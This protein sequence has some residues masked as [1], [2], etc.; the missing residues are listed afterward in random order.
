MTYEKI[1]IVGIHD[2]P[3]LAHYAPYLDTFHP[4]GGHVS[5]AKIPYLDT[6]YPPDGHV[7]VW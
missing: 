1:Y 6:F 5:I 3:R 7:S 2:P 4:P